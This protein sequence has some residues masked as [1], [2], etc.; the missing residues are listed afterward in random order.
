MPGQVFRCT[1]CNPMHKSQRN[2]LLITNDLG[3]H[4]ASC[5]G[6]AFRGMRTVRHAKFSHTLAD[7]VFTKYRD[8]PDGA[9]RVDAEPNLHNLGFALKHPNAPAVPV[10]QAQIVRADWLLTDQH[11]QKTLVD[12]TT[13]TPLRVGHLNGPLVYRNPGHAAKA[14]C[15]AKTVAYVKKWVIPQNVPLVI[16]AFEM[17]GRWH[18]ATSDLVDKYLSKRFPLKDRDNGHANGFSAAFDYVRKCISVNARIVAA[19]SALALV[20]SAYNGALVPVN[21]PAL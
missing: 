1:L 14:A 19:E 11:G 5:E 8:H 13:T 16:A 12:T 21:A 6:P 17:T 7:T 9:N 10:G 2:N 15:K 3:F 20:G 4:G 18:T